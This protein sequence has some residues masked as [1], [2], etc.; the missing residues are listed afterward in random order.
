ME[1]KEVETE[2][3]KK[4]KRNKGRKEEWKKERKTGNK[5]RKKGAQPFI[6]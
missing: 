3:R 4:E 2:E 1:Q 5:Y 6:Y